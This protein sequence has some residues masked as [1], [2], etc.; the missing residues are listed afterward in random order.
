MGHVSQWPGFCDGDELMSRSNVNASLIHELRMIIQTLAVSKGFHGTMP[1]KSKSTALKC[2]VCLNRNVVD[3][4]KD[5]IAILDG[6]SVCG[7]HAHM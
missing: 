5:A 1:R 3:E 2:I 7:D 6:K 4:P